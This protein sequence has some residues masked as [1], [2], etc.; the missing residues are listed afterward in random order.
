MPNAVAI[1]A[2][3]PLLVTPSNIVSNVPLSNCNPAALMLPKFKLN[4]S[5]TLLPRSLLTPCIPLYKPLPCSNIADIEAI[6]IVPCDL[7]P[8]SSPLPIKNL[9]SIPI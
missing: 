1:L 6:A 2:A 4:K 8:L 9:L 7:N 5:L 3:S